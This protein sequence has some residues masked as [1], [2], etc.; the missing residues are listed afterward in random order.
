MGGIHGA[1]SFM[2][3]PA[4]AMAIVDALEPGG[5]V[6]LISN[7]EEVL[8]AMLQDFLTVSPI[9][10]L[11]EW[12]RSPEDCSVM[13]RPDGSPFG[14]VAPIETEVVSVRKGRPIYRA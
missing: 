1:G 11:V 4:L 10:E 5:G 12:P 3:Q 13:W 2:V 9:T 6:A 8:Q 7:V 14:A